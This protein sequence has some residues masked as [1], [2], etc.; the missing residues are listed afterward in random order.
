MSCKW[1][2]GTRSRASRYEP[3]ELCEEHEGSKNGMKYP[4]GEHTLIR[5]E[6]YG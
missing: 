5:C 4:Q 2:K 6:S 3:C 1:G